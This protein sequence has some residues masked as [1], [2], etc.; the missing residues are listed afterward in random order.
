M[1]S[2]RSSR[3]R[4]ATDRIRATVPEMP[5]DARTSADPETGERWDR[6]Q[7][8]AHVAEILP[9]W[10]E[11]VELVVERGGGVPFGRVKTDPDRI[12]SI[13]RDRRLD[14]DELLRRIDQGLQQVLELLDRLDERALARTGTHERIGEM[15]AAAIIDRFLVDHLEEHAEQLQV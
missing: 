6:G 4:S 14:T 2:D 10:S 7:V 11:Q 13:E 15:T 3:L 8:L 1:P 5:D 9:Y 12:A